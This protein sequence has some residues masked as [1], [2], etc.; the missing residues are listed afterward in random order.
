MLWFIQLQNILNIYLSGVLW[1]FQ[2]V[3]VTCQDQSGSM[4]LDKKQAASVFSCDDAGFL[5]RV[6]TLVFFHLSFW[7]KLQNRLKKKKEYKWSFWV[8]FEQRLSGFFFH[9]SILVHWQKNTQGSC[10]AGSGTCDEFRSS[11]TAA[12]AQTTAAL[13]HFGIGNSIK[14]S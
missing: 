9:G 12:P 4:L 11:S 7:I 13:M 5:P 14:N 1:G 6:Y 10:E 8:A 3:Q 2:F